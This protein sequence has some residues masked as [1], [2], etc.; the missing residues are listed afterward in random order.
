MGIDE[1]DFNEEEYD[2]TE[3]TLRIFIKELRHT[4]SYY[5]QNK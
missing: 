4:I 1:P 3:S 2:S 5:P